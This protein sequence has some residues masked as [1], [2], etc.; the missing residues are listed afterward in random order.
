MFTIGDFAR[1][2]QVSVRM[3]CNYDATGLL[4][5]ARVNPASGYRFCEAVQFA[6]LNRIIAR[7]TSASPWTKCTPCW[8]ST[9]SSCAGCCGCAKP[10]RDRRSLPIRPGWRRPGEAPDH[11]VGGRHAS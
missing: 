6:R 7:K 11:R 4:R 5:P 8:T 1:H 10:S 3:L 2:G 9:S